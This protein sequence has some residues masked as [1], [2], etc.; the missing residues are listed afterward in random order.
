[1]KIHTHQP[2]GEMSDQEICRILRELADRVEA[3]RTSGRVFNS[4][5]DPCGSW[6]FSKVKGE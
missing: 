2:T 3:G 1:M 6:E 4:N 5:G